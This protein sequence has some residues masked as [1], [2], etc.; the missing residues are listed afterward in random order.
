MAISL[1]T[2]KREGQGNHK[3]KQENDHN[4]Q[5]WSLIWISGEW[6]SPH[7]YTHTTRSEESHHQKSEEQ[8]NH[9]RI[10][11]VLLESKD[12]WSIQF[13]SPRYLLITEL[14][15]TWSEASYS[16]L[17]S[18]MIK[19]IKKKGGGQDKEVQLL[20]MFTGGFPESVTWYFFL[21]FLWS[22]LVTWLFLAI[23]YLFQRPVNND[24]YS[25]R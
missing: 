16:H 10:N 24:F 21:T 22:E 4:N 12:G 17:H 18:R 8:G 7:T 23:K 3:C 19:E 20:S 2:R 5:P 15:F 25:L 13:P 14:W 6:R 11:T 9:G 1:T